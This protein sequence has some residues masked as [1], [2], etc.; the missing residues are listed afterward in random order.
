MTPV[1]RPLVRGVTEMVLYA[2]GCTV[3]G[4][5]SVAPSE[6]DATIAT[7]MPARSTASF[8]SVIPTSPAGTL[9]G[10]GPLVRVTSTSE[11]AGLDRCE[12]SHALPA[13]AATS[14]MAPTTRTPRLIVTVECAAITGLRA[15]ASERRALHT[16]FSSFPSVRVRCPK[17]GGAPRAHRP[18]SYDPVHTPV[19]PRRGSSSPVRR[20]RQSPQAP[21]GQPRLGLRRRRC[22]PP[23]PVVSRRAAPLH[24]PAPPELRQCRP[25]SCF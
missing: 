15:P 6:E 13:P 9:A 2:F 1:T 19:A 16:R 3:P 10:G 21:G 4:I 11:A 7:A 18:L 5:R 17:S 20:P 8:D 12:I 23:P 25:D 14:P 22:R 24:L